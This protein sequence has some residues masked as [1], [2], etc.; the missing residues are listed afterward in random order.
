MAELQCVYSGPLT[1]VRGWG[2]PISANKAHYFIARRSLCGRWA[3]TG[4]LIRQGEA[5]PSR[6]DCKSCRRALDQRLAREAADAPRS[7]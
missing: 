1:E 5:K 2:W 7:D 6:D 3:F 4:E